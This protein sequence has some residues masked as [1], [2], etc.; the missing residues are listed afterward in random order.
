MPRR[1]QAQRQSDRTAR[2]Q[3]RGAARVERA[4]TRAGRQIGRAQARGAAQVQRATGRG[5]VDIMRAEAA[6][7]VA[8]ADPSGASRGQRRRETLGRIGAG[9]LGLGESLRDVAG[10]IFGG[11]SDGGAVDA[12]L[13]EE[14]G[15][16]PWLPILGV[17]AAG[18]AAFFLLKGDGDV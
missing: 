9:V 10:D 2:Q 4:A 5:V 12:P 8:L 6:Q 13:T 7:E 3:R 15:G 18:A 16:I 1:T 11:G 14:R 17:A